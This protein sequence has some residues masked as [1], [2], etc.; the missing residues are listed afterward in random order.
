MVPN[1]YNHEIDQERM[2]AHLSGEHASL[3]R[4]NMARKLGVFLIVLGT[5][6]KRLEQVMRPK[7]IPT[8]SMSSLGSPHH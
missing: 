4:E 7:Q 2:L 8:K 3:M 6:L 1:L 5:S